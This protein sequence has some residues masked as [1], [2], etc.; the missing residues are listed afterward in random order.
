MCSHYS[1]N[2]EIKCEICDK[3]SSCHKCHDENNAR[4][5]AAASG[6]DHEFIRNEL[7]TIKCNSC[8]IIQ[9]PSNSNTCISCDTKY[10]E[11]SCI[12]CCY[13]GEYE[14]I[15]CDVCCICYK[16]NSTHKCIPNFII[17]KC[18][19][20]ISNLHSSNCINIDCG[21]CFHINCLFDYVKKC[22]SPSCPLCRKPFGK[23]TIFCNYCKES[24]YGNPRGTML[25]C[26]HYFHME[27][28]KYLP[29]LYYSVEDGVLG[30]A[31]SS[32]SVNENIL[33]SVECSKSDCR[34]RHIIKKNIS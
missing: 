14:T 30:A 26:G 3:F 5:S 1:R 12:K 9:C 34:R 18:S 28:L 6:G 17:E 2:I 20:C 33:H 15:H 21:H 24:F 29:A 25:N 22:E 31:S 11:Y 7:K 19:I 8:N 32:S 23:K 10:A 27:C 16:Q 13:F 4:E